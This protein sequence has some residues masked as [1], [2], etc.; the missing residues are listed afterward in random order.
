MS[1]P[2][3]QSVFVNAA[4]ARADRLLRQVERA[5]GDRLLAK[6]RLADA[7]NL[8]DWMSSRPQLVSYALKAHLDFV[9]VKADGLPIFAVEID[10][11]Q[12]SR[13]SRQ[14][15]RDEMKD[16]LCRAAGLPL[17]RINSEFGR[18]EGKR[19]LLEYLCDAFYKS[20]AFEDAQARGAIPQDEPFNHASF[21]EHDPETGGF[22]FG[23]LD[24]R[25]R[26]ELHRLYESQRIPQFAPDAWVADADE[27]GDVRADVYLGVGDGY[28]LATSSKVRQFGYFGIS[29]GELAE[30]L[31]V[32]DLHRDA[33]RWLA[34]DPVAI[35]TEGFQQWF[36]ELQA[37]AR[38]RMSF[39]ASGPRWLPY[40]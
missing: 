40:P 9:M 24:A 21:I 38:I 36:R 8:G 22:Y 1:G 31:A 37:S 11:R 3:V 12:H 27:W 29:S 26:A 16:E 35:S 7:L 14:R 19:T 2:T 28:V 6:V 4:E 32:C 20:V 33:L 10:G 15:R 17:L 34:G 30:E 13:D 5:N 39:G 23:T 25:P 18:K